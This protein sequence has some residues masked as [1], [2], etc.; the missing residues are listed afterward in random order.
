MNYKEPTDLEE[1]DQMLE[2]L[3]KELEGFENI[4]TLQTASGQINTFDLNQAMILRQNAMR[5]IVDILGKARQLRNLAKRWY[6]L[7]RA[8]ERLQANQMSEIYASDGDRKAYA[9]MKAEPYRIRH[10]IARTFVDCVYDQRKRLEDYG[11]DLMQ[12]GH[13]IRKEMTLG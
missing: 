8:K 1:F 7:T 13:N 5:A 10:D 9:E 4:E 11:E 6:D 3:Q 12:I 2:L